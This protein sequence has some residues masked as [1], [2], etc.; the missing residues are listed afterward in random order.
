MVDSGGFALMANPDA[1][2]T[3]RDVSKFIADLDAEIFVS[4]DYPPAKTDSKKARE[5]KIVRSGRNFRIL[6]ERFPSKTIMPV[7]HGRTVS[8]ID[9]SIQLI[10]K[11]APRPAWVGLGGI[12]PLL[13]HRLVSRE[14]T[15][16]SPEVFI[17]VSLAKIRNAFPNARIHAFGA[18]GTQTFPAVVAL[19]ADSADSIGWRQAAGF[20][21][22]FLPLRSQRVIKWNLEKRP[23]RK[24]LDESDIAQLELCVCPICTEKPVM[25]SRL[26]DFRSSYRNRSIH[27][28]WAVTHQ[29]KYWPPGRSGIRNLVAKGDLGLAWAKALDVV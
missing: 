24:L 11:V 18:G 1:Y 14:I 17:A 22:I 27:N 12:V 25:A 6:T 15:R 28:A 9:R 29:T 8:E 3:L 16:Q 13:Q 10:G 26:A 5:R 7:V 4:L 21:S 20:G 23:P 19:G 2:W